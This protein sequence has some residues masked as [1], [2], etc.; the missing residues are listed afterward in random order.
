[1]PGWCCWWSV[2]RLSWL[3]S[4]GP[5]SAS[6]TAIRCRI[7]AHHRLS[8]RQRDS[9]TESGAQ[10]FRKR[11]NRWPKWRRIALLQSGFENLSS[12]KT[13]PGRFR[14]ETT[15][16]GRTR[17]RVTR[18]ASSQTTASPGRRAT[19]GGPENATD[20]MER[21]HRRQE[22]DAGA[23]FL[24]TGQSVNHG[25]AGLWNWVEG[26]SGSD[27]FDTTSRGGTAVSEGRVRREIPGSLLVSRLS[28]RRSPPT[29]VIA[30]H[31]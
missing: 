9:R 7:R 21:A 16:R 3:R 30:S 4:W 25:W 5:S 13:R 17:G 19:S 27:N 1:M 2:A 12:G 15:G 31:R 14:L 18:Q 11:S 24:A 29:H 26:E 6:A 28:A 8:R 23:V 10:T 20:A 22:V